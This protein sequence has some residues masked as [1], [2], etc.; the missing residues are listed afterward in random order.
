MQDSVGY[1]SFG[2]EFRLISFPPGMVARAAAMD[3]NIMGRRVILDAVRGFVSWM[4]PSRTHET[5]SNAAGKVIDRAAGM[6]GTDISVGFNGTRFRHRDDPPN[7]GMEP[8]S[9]FCIGAN[10]D[11]YRA[12]CRNGSGDAFIL[13]VP[14]DLVIETE[15]FHGDPDKPGRWAALGVTEMWRLERG[16]PS[17]E[18]AQVEILSLRPDVRAL[19]ESRLLPGLA[20]ETVSEAVYLVCCARPGEMERFLEKALHPED[21]GSSGPGI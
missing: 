13:S 21:P 3:W 5:V 8:D 16:A 11:R 4:S 18:R 15:V 9:A 10:A 19:P 1:G 20:P 12:A 17:A 6:T 2:S 7:T 14:P